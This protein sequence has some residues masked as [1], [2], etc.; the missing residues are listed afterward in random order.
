MVALNESSQPSLVSRSCRAAVLGPVPG[1]CDRLNYDSAGKK[2]ACEYA[3][4][5]NAVGDA[6]GRAV[7][8]CR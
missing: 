6:Q 3:K 5:I 7:K 4:V 1:P 2:K 8:L